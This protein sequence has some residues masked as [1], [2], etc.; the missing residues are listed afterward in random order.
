MQPLFNLKSFVAVMIILIVPAAL[1][2][3]Y[4]RNYS[5]E[6]GGHEHGGAATAGQGSDV[7]T[8]QSSGHSH[9]AQGHRNMAMPQGGHTHSGKEAESA[10]APRAG[11]DDSM[12]HGTMK[13]SSFSQSP[14]SAQTAEP[15]RATSPREQL[16][17]ARSS[18][19]P[20][21]PGI[22]CLYH[23]G[24]TGFFLNAPEY[25]SL[26][27][28]QKSALNRMKQKAVLGS[29][30]AKRRIEEA[31]QEL[32]E[33]TGADDPDSTQIQAKVQTIESLRRAQRMAFINSVGEAAKV[34]TDEQR[35]VLLG[36]R[37]ASI[38][39]DK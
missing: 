29:Y 8:M 28:E 11:S 21:I 12:E 33:L 32:W 26:S 5:A 19:L 15:A 4:F 1:L 36:T 20:G 10:S 16:D 2:V 24:G 13:Q 35:Q 39:V 6:R 38:P 18:L 3:A 30:T 7:S 14:S 9:S 34:L 25:I 31:E 17:F 23:I 27:I 22:S 37:E